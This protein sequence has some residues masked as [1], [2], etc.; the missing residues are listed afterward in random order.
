MFSTLHLQHLHRLACLPPSIC[1]RPL[2]LKPASSRPLI[3]P[4]LSPPGSKRRPTKPRVIWYETLKTNGRSCEYS[5]TQGSIRGRPTSFQGS[6]PC[7]TCQVSIKSGCGAVGHEGQGQLRSNHGFPTSDQE[8]TDHLSFL[9]DRKMG[10][11]LCT[12]LG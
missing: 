6:Q 1:I 11:K 5:K 3:F 9:I 8:G 10:L 12:Y 7:A 4:L 2:V